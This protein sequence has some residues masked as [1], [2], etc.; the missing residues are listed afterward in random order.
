[1][2]N[3]E[4]IEAWNTVLFDKFTRYRATL[5]TM[6]GVHGARAIARHAPA[7]GTRVVDIGCGFGE[8]TIE[9]ARRAGS[10]V[11]ID[12]A[13]RFVAAARES[14]ARAGVDSARF[15]VADVEAGVPGGPFDLAFSRMG[16][17]FFASPVIALRNIRTALR[18]GGTLCMVVWRKKDANPCLHVPELVARE[19]LGEPDKNDQVTCGPGP[20]SMA[21]ADLVGD[22]LVAA[23]YTD[24]AFE[25]SDADV[26]IGRDLDEAV[27]FA[28]ELGPAGEIVRLA[29]D[30]AVRRRPELDR[31]MKSALAPHLRDG[32][33]RAASSCWIVTARVP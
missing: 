15:E 3:A 17:M 1:M 29:G 12:A 5:D 6:L 26:A 8:T 21:S 19:L 27:Q 32:A 13:P 4:A 10:A 25:R 7:A 28:I 9:L 16:T 24:L 11:G 2:V 20:F 33:V 31:A 23:G 22:Q 30:E 18:A 14:A